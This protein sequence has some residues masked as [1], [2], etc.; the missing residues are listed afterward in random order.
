MGQGELSE[1]FEYIPLPL[2]YSLMQISASISPKKLF[3]FCDK[4]TY[5][6]ILVRPNKIPPPSKKPISD[7]SIRSLRL[8]LQDLDRCLAAHSSAGTPRTEAIV[9]ALHTQ[10]YRDFK[11]GKQCSGM[12]GLPLVTFCLR[13]Y[14]SDQRAFSIAVRADHIPYHSHWPLF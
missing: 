13:R 2:H 5:T 9:R 8:L 3:H 10:Y 4:S 12:H 11:R 14:V 7:F 1:N 6:M